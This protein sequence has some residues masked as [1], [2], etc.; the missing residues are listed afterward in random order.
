MIMKR[1]LSAVLLA[2]AST[3]ALAGK[4]LPEADK[5]AVG[6]PMSVS[7][8]PE[9]AAEGLTRW[10]H[11]FRYDDASFVKAH[12]RNLNLR[13]GDALVLRSESGKV[14][15]R[16]TGRG[17]KDRGTFWTL[18]AFG[19]R[20]HMRLEVTSG[21]AY[22]EPPFTIDKVITGYPGM[23]E[24]GV[25][26]NNLMTPGDNQVAS[27]CTPPDFEDVACY[28]DDAGKW[29]NVQASVG[30]MDAGNGGPSVW[31]SGS[32]ISPTNALLTNYHCI[33]SQAQC[34]SSEFVFKYYR[35][36]CND[37]S[38]PTADWVSFRC[39][40][41]LASSP[42]GPCDAT[43][44]Q[45][46][47]ML[48]S[49]IGDPAS[50]FGHVE[51]DPTPLA[52]G[53][54]IYIIQ[55]P[56]GRPHEITHGG[57]GDVEVDGP[58]LRYY[59]TLDTEGGSSGSPIFRESDDRL[60]GL[61]HC[62]GCSSAGVGNRG[63]LMS[64]I[65]PEI[66]EFLCT[67]SVG[68]QASG[69]PVLTETAGNGDAVIDPGETWSFTP[70]VLN[71]ACSDTALSVS[72]T[73]EPAAGSTGLITIP[74]P[75]VN[76]GDIPAAQTQPASTP[77]DVQID[78]AATCGAEFSIDL[79]NVMGSGTSTVDLSGMAS[80]RIGMADLDYRFT[81]DFGSGLGDWT[82]VDNGTGSGTASTW[83][84]QD[85]GD[86]SL[87]DPPFVIADSDA[88]GSSDTMDEELISPVID[89]SGAAELFLEFDHNFRWY[90]LGGNEQADVDVR[91]S[92]T[93]GSW[94][95]VA[96]YSGGSASGFVSLDITAHAAADLQIRFHYYQA[97]FD[98]W[99]AV[100]NIAVV[101]NNGFLCAPGAEEIFIDG[102]EATAR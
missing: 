23:F 26:D 58:V 12:I 50:Q 64:D 41:V 27:V 95:N 7:I 56:S 72:A 43:L 14:V 37:G 90:D 87:L 74:S 13:P 60:V 67:Q 53:E 59:N 46:D 63:M 84:D 33:A 3:V 44:S 28:D 78:P 10:S 100:D 1:I 24:S 9:V 40:E 93:G 30:V 92:A 48:T 81:E 57:A 5:L 18:S 86:R 16:L 96:N 29:A 61:H 42:D 75:V 82:I 62:G 77:V 98:W 39:D 83:T 52:S 15:E 19:S 22:P 54:D 2:L 36:G 45:L 89:A 76:F 94:V 69:L 97:D 8:V 4:P 101:I 71:T 70:E 66:S 88:L 35:T 49:V 91:S 38:P 51:P 80:G 21:H 6:S 20:L 25:S 79:T 73:A 11:E 65:Y 31:C 99:W 68:F 85:P 102:F 32:N 47:Y 17:P 34:D 55:H